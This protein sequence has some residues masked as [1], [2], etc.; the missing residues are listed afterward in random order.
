MTVTGENKLTSGKLKLVQ[1]EKK[2]WEFI[3]T[4]RNHP[5]VKG[6]FIEQDHIPSASHQRYMEEYGLS[7]Y[8]CLC[9]NLPA[10]FVG[11]IDDDIRVATHPDFQGK[12]VGVFMINE[13]MKIYPTSY[14]KVKVENEASVGLFEKAGFIKKYYI[15]EKA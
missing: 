7:Y 8:V 12:G 15:L 2:Y 9:D 14:A 10:G 11:S 6:G 1:N 3:R 13:L 5:E 4:L